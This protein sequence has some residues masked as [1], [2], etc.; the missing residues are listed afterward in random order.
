MAS[1]VGTALQDSSKVAW[2]T[3]PT[4][5]PSN[6][7][8]LT[9]AL[10]I[11][12]A[13]ISAHDCDDSLGYDLAPALRAAVALIDEAEDGDRLPDALSTKLLEASGIVKACVVT[14][15]T[16][17]G[18]DW[19]VSWALLPVVRL[20]DEVIADLRPRSDHRP[21]ARRRSAATWCG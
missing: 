17:H 21:R 13:V 14:H 6:L 15:T 11:L 7:E 1:K 16:A 12:R 5:P 8:R 18:F 4:N 19:D 2:L 10:S 3:V 9:Q 20:I